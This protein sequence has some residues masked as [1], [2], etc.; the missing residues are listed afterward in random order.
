[1]VNMKLN[2]EIEHIYLNPHM[3]SNQNSEYGPDDDMDADMV[4]KDIGY[5]NDLSSLGVRPY[6]TDPKKFTG[7]RYIVKAKDRKK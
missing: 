1:M 6:T 7:S 4:N 2:I 3:D 5:K